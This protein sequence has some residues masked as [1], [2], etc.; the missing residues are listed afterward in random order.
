MKKIILISIVTSGILFGADVNNL[1]IDQHNEVDR[2]KINAATIKQGETRIMGDAQVNN[3]TIRQKANGNEIE[4]SVINSTDVLDFS[5]KEF[6][7]GEYYDRKRDDTLISQG[8]T[9]LIDGKV[10]NVEIDSDS[11]IMNGTTINAAIGNSVKIDQG[12]T[13]VEGHGQQLTNAKITSDNQILNS[14][15]EGQ[16]EGSTSIK[17]ANFILEEEGAP[18]VARDIKVDSTNIIDGAIIGHANIKQS[19]TEVEDGGIFYDSNLKQ[20][21]SII[22]ETEIKKFSEISQGTTSIESSKASIQQEV[23]NLIAD[24]QGE[25]SSAVAS[26]IKQADIEVE[27]NS[28][29]TLVYKNHTNSIRNVDLQDSSIRQDI[30]AINNESKVDNFR[31]QADNTV[32]SSNLDGS[33]INQNLLSVDNA[34]LSGDTASVSLQTNLVSDTNLMDS[35]VSQ[36]DI[37]IINSK[38][39]A[40]SVSEDNELKDSDLYN[41]YLTQGHLIISGL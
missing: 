1:K 12:L 30:T 38:V 36:A 37:K 7:E 14:N 17:Q 23:T 4:D 26:E 15:I 16:G 20:H 39:E 34:T 22:G 9:I 6:Q 24:V 25:S 27:G 5:S 18:S 19:Y 21:N 35:Y 11:Q 31:Q 2:T 13:V 32:V 8:R 10:E 40:L 33:E 3:L 28:D 41:T 29:V